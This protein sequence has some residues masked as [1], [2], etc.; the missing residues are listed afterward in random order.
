[1]RLN[2]DTVLVG[3]KVALVPYLKEHVARWRMSHITLATDSTI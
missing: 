3:T 2:Q 1:M